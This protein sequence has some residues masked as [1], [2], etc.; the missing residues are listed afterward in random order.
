[1]ENMSI[2]ALFVS[3]FLC[4]KKIIRKLKIVNLVTNSYPLS[5]IISEHYVERVVIEVVI[6][7]RKKKLKLG[8]INIYVAHNNYD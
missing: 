2:F 8:T 3:K 5:K 4:K 7:F 1:M 6:F